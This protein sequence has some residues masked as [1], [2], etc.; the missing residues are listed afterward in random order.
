MAGKN[1]TKC[2]EFKNGKCGGEDSQCIC[3]NCPR[4]MGMCI[5]TRW[6]RETESEI[7]FEENFN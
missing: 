2:P 1:C 5:I 6:C 7:F 3:R 4:N